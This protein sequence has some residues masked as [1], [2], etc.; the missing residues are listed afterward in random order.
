MGF[1]PTLAEKRGREMN[2]RA[3]KWSFALHMNK[4]ISIALLIVGCV[5]VVYGLNAS[6]SIGSDVSRAVTGAPT[7]KTIWLLVGGIVAAVIGLFGLFR[8]SKSH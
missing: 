7:D 3:T 8:G 4:P 2:R 6:D 1:M 5:L